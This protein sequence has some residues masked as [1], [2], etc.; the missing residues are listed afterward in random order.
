[1]SNMINMKKLQPKDKMLVVKAVADIAKTIY[2][3]NTTFVLNYI[4]EKGE[5]NSEFGKF[6]NSHSNAKTVQDVI[7]S[8][9]AQIKK[10]QN[11][12]AVLKTIEDKNI[13]IYA[14]AS[15]TL[16]SKH[17]SVADDIAKQLLADLYED[18][19]YNKLVKATK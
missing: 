19:G 17:S 6:Y 2:S 10:L 14:D 15:D 3:N 16:C 1:M 4:L 11:E 13:T 18:L 5:Y 12:I 8:K 9:K 7:D